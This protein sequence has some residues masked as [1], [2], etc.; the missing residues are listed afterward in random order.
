MKTQRRHLKPI[1]VSAAIGANA[2]L[3]FTS[4]LLLF[5]PAPAAIERDLLHTGFLAGAVAGAIT[6]LMEINDPA[7]RRPESFERVIFYRWRNAVIDGEIDIQ[8]EMET[9]VKSVYGDRND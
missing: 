3:L 4:A 2:A 5:A 8:L 9:L 1:A 6:K 7:R